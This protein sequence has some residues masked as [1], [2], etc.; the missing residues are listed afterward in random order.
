VD[1]APGFAY[2]VDWDGR[3]RVRQRLHWV[4]CEGLG[5]ATVLWRV[6]G[7]T[8]Y[9]DRYA[10]WW[11]YADR[12]LIDRE[13]GSWHHEL[14]PENRPAATIRPGKADVYH[15]FQ[16]TLLPRVPLAP[17]LATAIEARSTAIEAR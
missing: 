10:E 11:Q 16:A 6:T 13:H 3:P 14:D 9:R 1:G 5:A 17:S 15:A 8:A 12:Y 4:L 7:R 2:T